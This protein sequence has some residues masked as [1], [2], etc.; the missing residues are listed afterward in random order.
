MDIVHEIKG[1]AEQRPVA[2]HRKVPEGWGK[3]PPP[4]PP[5]PAP[6]AARP[7]QT[8]AFATQGLRGA[9]LRVRRSDGVLEVAL[10]WGV[11]FMQA[12]ALALGQ[13]V[14]F[15]AGVAGALEAVRE[16]GFLVVQLP[17]GRC[18]MNLHSLVAAEP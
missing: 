7:Q 12:R 4:P 8:L 11:A 13:R 10:P 2:P 14:A 1:G 6:P 5:A 9:L 3:P 16:D 15:A 17:Y 18:F